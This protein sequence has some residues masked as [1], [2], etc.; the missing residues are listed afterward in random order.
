MEVVLNG[1]F[2]NEADCSFK[3]NNRA[4]LY[5]DGFFETLFIKNN[6]IPH[7]SEHYNRIKDAFTCFHY[8]TVELP[9]EETF[10]ELIQQCA[11]KNN[12]DFGRVKMIFWRSEGGLY[13]PTSTSFQFLITVL[14]LTELNTKDKTAIISSH[15]HNAESITSRYKTLNA[16]NYV[17]A[18]LELSKTTADDI[19]LLDQHNHI[20]EALYS[21]I[22]FV[23]EN[24]IHTPSLKTG[25]IN[26]IMRQ[27]IIKQ[28]KGSIT[29][30]EFTET[31]L[32]R[33]D[34]V[35]TTNSLSIQNITKI[36]QTTFSKKEQATILKQTLLGKYL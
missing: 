1:K 13:T 18:G 9:S 36:G 20:S 35:F 34:E 8:N 6:Y 12:L 10:I 7:F 25:C 4:F 2:I 15:N 28:F 29:E 26:G 24:N 30:G 19:L 33:A 3:T 22:F 32:L 5:G 14:P 27:L 17:L 21:N 31:D 23:I 11:S 16:L